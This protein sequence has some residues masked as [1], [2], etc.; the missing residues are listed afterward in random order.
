MVEEHAP[1]G[2]LFKLSSMSARICL[3]LLPMPVPLYRHPNSEII[4]TFLQ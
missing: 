4:L 1:F 3:C 2:D